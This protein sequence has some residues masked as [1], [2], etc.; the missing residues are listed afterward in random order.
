MLSF[1]RRLSSSRSER[2]F[3]N[4]MGAPKQ[5]CLIAETFQLRRFWISVMRSPQGLDIF[6]ISIRQLSCSR[7]DIP[8]CLLMYYCIIAAWKKKIFRIAYEV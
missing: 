4:S 1:D 2:H 6:R 7:W 3:G 8:L 5:E